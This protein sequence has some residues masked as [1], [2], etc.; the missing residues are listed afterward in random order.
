MPGGDVPAD[1][2]LPRQLLSGGDGEP[3]GVSGGF[4]LRD[5]VVEGGVP[6]LVLLPA[7]VT[8][9]H[10]VPGRLLVPGGVGG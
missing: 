8:E 7:G 2:L 3:D 4:L 10:E 9:R 1:G 5:C 6:C